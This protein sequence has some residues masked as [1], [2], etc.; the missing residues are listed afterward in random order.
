MNF[1]DIRVIINGSEIYT[2]RNN[3]SIVIPLFRKKN[4]IVATD[5]YHITEPLELLC[6]QRATYLKVVCGIDND[7][8]VAGIIMLVFS[9]LIGII[10]EI[11]L[12]KFLSFVPIFY[13]LF[14]YYLKRREFIQIK[15]V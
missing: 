9:S 8:L 15:P 14:L 11:L 13:F 6:H 12:A 5:G 10:S 4:K 7:K 1:L 3:K 2:L